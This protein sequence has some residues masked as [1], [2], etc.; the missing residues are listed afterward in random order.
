MKILITSGGTQVPIDSVRHIG[1]VSTGRFA[2]ALAIALMRAGHEIIFF[3]QF[4]SKSPFKLEIDLYDGKNKPVE[5]QIAEYDQLLKEIGTTI[6]ELLSLRHLYREE[7]FITYQ[8]YASK[9]IRATTKEKPDIVVAA[10]A[11]SDYETDSFNGK[12]QSADELTIHLKPSKKVLPLIKMAHPETRLIG[13]KLL[14]AATEEDFED[15]VARVMAS[16]PC[17]MVAANDLK[18]LEAGRHNY[19]LHLADGGSILLP[20]GPD[21]A[22]RFALEILRTFGPRQ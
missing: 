3:R 2:S 7:T 8:E 6:S 10:A 22:E 5:E 21:L 16:G 1:N 12:L 20:A 17:D 19:R 18:E 14:V 11:V 9:L 13:F 15:A 4:Y